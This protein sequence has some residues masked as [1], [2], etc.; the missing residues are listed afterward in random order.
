MDAFW[1]FLPDNQPEGLVQDYNSACKKLFGTQYDYSILAQQQANSQES[2]FNELS[3]TQK[4]GRPIHNP[5]AIKNDDESNDL[6]FLSRDLDS[7]VKENDHK[8][9]YGSNADSNQM[10]AT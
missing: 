4:D 10:Q 7:L 6:S 8:N 9:G 2:V 1:P 3:I 5:F